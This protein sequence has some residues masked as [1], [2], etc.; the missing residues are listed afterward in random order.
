[1]TSLDFLYIAIGISVILLTIFLCV[2]LLYTILILRDASKVAENIKISSDKIKD[3]VLDPLKTL[4]EFSASFAFI[5]AILEKLKA[6][7][8]NEIDL[9]DTAQE[10]KQSKSFFRK[11]KIN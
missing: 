1:M 9:E 2:L 7:F 4:A 3:T 5:G 10:N 11:K 8:G 6:R